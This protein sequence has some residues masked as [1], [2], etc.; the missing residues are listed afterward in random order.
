M[1]RV[2]LSGY[3]GVVQ[4]ID[5]IEQHSIRFIL[6]LFI[7]HVQRRNTSLQSTSSL[8]K[9]FSLRINHGLDTDHHCYFNS[10]RQRY[11]HSA[12]KVRYLSHRGLHHYR[13][14]HQ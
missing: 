7:T 14:H 9:S 5:N 1:A 6:N 3:Y 8:N 12:D 2:N 4:R 13:H 11:Q 10:H